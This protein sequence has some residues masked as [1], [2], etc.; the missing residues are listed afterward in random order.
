MAVISAAN[1]KFYESTTGP[2]RG[3]TIN[4]GAEVNPATLFDAVTGDEALAGEDEYRGIF[5]KN[6]DA[7][8]G[9]LQNAVLWVETQTPG[10]DSVTI[11]PC[12]EGASAAMETIADFFTPPSGP[13]FAACANKG[14]G[15]SLGT[16]AQNAYF[17]IWI[18]RIV[19]ASCAAYNANS[20]V[21]K[22]E[23]DSSA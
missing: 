10:G 11:A 9:G 20:F 22:V 17:G 6:T 21:L 2:N 1:L 16:L 12:D 4:V 18:K 7:N 8:A 13:T 3:G 19:P 15:L 5:F 14:A 23:G